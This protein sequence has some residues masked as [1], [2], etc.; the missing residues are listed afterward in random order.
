MRRSH[1]QC[2]YLQIDSNSLK[3]NSD[4]QICV[5]L[6][7]LTE[8]LLVIRKS[9]LTFLLSPDH[10]PPWNSNLN[11]PEAWR[12]FKLWIHFKLISRLC[13]AM[14]FGLTLQSKFKRIRLRAEI[15]IHLHSQAAM[16]IQPFNHT[17]N[18]SVTLDLENLHNLN[19]C[20]KKVSYQTLPL[21]CKIDCKMTFLIL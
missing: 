16:D 14:E 13:Q 17:K 3:R 1:Y 15:C 4:D 20:S 12:V 18:E 10:P 7:H 9:P 5:A 11:R 6:L 2:R 8:T 19:V 21:Y